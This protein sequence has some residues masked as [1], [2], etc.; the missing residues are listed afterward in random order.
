MNRDRY[1]LARSQVQL[2]RAL[3]YTDQLAG[4][5]SRL[6]AAI[7]IIQKFA[8]ESP[9][10]IPYRKDLAT[11]H[12]TLGLIRSE[13]GEPSLAEAEFRA[14]VGDLPGVGK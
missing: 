12:T 14:L 4:A 7:S 2:G 6:D 9:G 11:S 8:D 5:E 13:R 1:S 10:V 3:I